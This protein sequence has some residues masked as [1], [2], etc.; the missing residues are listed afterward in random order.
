MCFGNVSGRL[1]SGSTRVFLAGLG[2]SDE[3]RVFLVLLMVR[4]VIGIRWFLL[5]AS[6]QEPVHAPFHVNSGAASGARCVLRASPFVHAQVM[7]AVM[8][9]GSARPSPARGSPP[10]RARARHVHACIAELLPLYGTRFVSLGLT[11]PLQLLDRELLSFPAKSRPN[12]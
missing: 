4:T 3:K 8:V 5:A 1:E 10:N 7:S 2:A 6:I 12:Q 9:N 11:N